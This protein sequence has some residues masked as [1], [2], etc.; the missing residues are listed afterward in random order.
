MD[1]SWDEFGRIVGAVL[2]RFSRQGAR[3]APTP[4]DVRRF[5]RQLREL[6]EHRG[7]PRALRD[8]ECGIPGSMSEAECAPLVAQVVAGLDDAALAD[9]ARQFVKACFYPEFKTCRDSFR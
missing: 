6:I 8:D 3:P 4:H 7:L 2:A 9:A 1:E 5:V